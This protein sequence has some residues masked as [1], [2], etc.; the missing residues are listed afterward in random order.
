MTNPSSPTAAAKPP[1]TIARKLPA[2][3]QAAAPTQAKAAV[4][5]PVRAAR[6]PVPAAVL[7]VATKTPAKT[8]P[9]VKTT[10]P[11]KRAVPAKTPAPAKASKPI[12]TAGKAEASKTSAKAVTDKV[13]KDGKHSGKKPK[14]VRDSFT[15]PAV[16]YA[17]FGT[18]KQRALKSGHEVKK[19]ELLRA[20]LASLAALPDSA[21]L[22]ALQGINRLKPG[23]PV[24]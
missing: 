2:K 24:K 7:P 5:T 14:L 15:F 21:L 20:G 19:S 8:T 9:T 12:A 3:A 18:L 11:V 13:A 1:K 17:L 23:R 16:D 22:K 6:Q 4:K 10:A